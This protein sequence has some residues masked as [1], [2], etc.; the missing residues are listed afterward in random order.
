MRHNLGTSGFLYRSNKLMYD[1]DTQSLW[2]TIWGQPVVG[3]LV[4]RGIV[5]ERLSVVT[6]TWGEWRR[7]HPDTK[8]LSLNTGYDR[9]YTEGAATGSILPR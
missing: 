7:R 6:T 4:D 5:L 3:P 1:Q 8:V 9:D 2:N